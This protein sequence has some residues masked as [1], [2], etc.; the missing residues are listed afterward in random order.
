MFKVFFPPHEKPKKVPEV[1]RIFLQLQKA[2][3]SIKHVA[4]TPYSQ[5]LLVSKLKENWYTS[6]LFDNKIITE[7]KKDISVISI[8]QPY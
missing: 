4:T 6:W 7:Q 8:N 1:T 2:R 3:I 5:A